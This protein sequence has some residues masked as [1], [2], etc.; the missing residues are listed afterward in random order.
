MSQLI[1]E[2]HRLKLNLSEAEQITLQEAVRHHRHP[3][4]R[5]RC[6]ALLKIAEGY[7]PHWVARHGLLVSRD[8]DSVYQWLSYYQQGGIAALLSHRHGGIQRRRLR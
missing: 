2:R 7:S 1:K 4:V 6:A 5:E 3:G 8:P